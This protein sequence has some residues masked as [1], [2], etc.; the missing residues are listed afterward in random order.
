MATTTPLKDGEATARPW[1]QLGNSITA[2]DDITV[3][4]IANCDD[5]DLTQ[6]QNEANAALIVEAVNQYDAL[7]EKADAYDSLVKGFAEA[8]AERITLRA[9]LHELL[10]EH[11]LEPHHHGLCGLCQRADAMIGGGK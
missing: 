9:L 10:T 8:T 7:K 4:L 2:G 6:G 3:I 11:R 5:H 1:S